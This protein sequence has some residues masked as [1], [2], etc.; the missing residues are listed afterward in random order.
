[1]SSV[2]VP[3]DQHDSRVARLRRVAI[4]V[5]LPAL[6]LAP[7]LIPPAADARTLRGNNVYAYGDGKVNCYVVHY[8]GTGIECMSQAVPSG[9]GDGYL[10]LRRTGRARVGARGDYPG[11]GGTRRKL[12][13]G[14]TWR[15]GHS[16]RGITCAIQHGVVKCINRSGHGI[17]L[18]PSEYYR[19]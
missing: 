15:P 10:A 1:M 6:L 14:D 3:T 8:G 2:T 4:R 18:S 19:F 16:A 7:L 11:Y 17:A 12:R 13:S 5:A 9:D